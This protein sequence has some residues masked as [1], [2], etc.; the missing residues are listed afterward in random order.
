MMDEERIAL[1]WSRGCFVCG[2]DNPI[3]LRAR[4][5]L[6][7][8]TTVELPFTPDAAHA[9]WNEVVHGGLITTV[10]DEVMTWAAIVALRRACFA[11]DFTVRLRRPLPPGTACRALAR[12]EGQRRR[13]L[14]T[15]AELLGEDGTLFASAK[16]RYMSI[17]P[18]KVKD[19]EHDLVT[20][21]GT[22][23][24]DDIFGIRSHDR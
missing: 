12:S 11:A 1:P 19:M 9:G 21:P 3:G 13:V 23:P 17:P 16:G 15:S 7:D 22:W 20:E 2:A 18:E 8:G 6:V 24:V 14:D 4:S 5:Y 10:L